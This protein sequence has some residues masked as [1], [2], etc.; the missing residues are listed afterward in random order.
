MFSVFYDFL[1]LCFAFYAS[2]K[3]LVTNFSNLLSGG[4]YFYGEH[5][6]L[7]APWLSVLRLSLRVIR[8]VLSIFGV[9]YTTLSV[10]KR[11]SWI[12]D[13]LLE[14]R[15]VIFTCACLAPLVYRL[16]TMFDERKTATTTRVSRRPDGTTATTTVCVTRWY[17]N[18]VLTREDC[19]ES[20][21]FH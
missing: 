7:P 20:T 19:H 6:G 8:P 3:D 14:Y 18:G 2:H 13:A 21:V 16:R 5:F 15:A 10:Y 9:L 1:Q 11:F 17:R 4:V 12:C